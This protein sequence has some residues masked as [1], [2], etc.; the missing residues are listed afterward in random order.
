MIVVI[1]IYTRVVSQEGM[2]DISDDAKLNLLSNW[3]DEIIQGIHS[4]LQAFAQQA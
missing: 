2:K 1:A 4:F 3:K